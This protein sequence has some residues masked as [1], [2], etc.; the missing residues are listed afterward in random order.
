MTHVIV[1]RWGKNLALRFPNEIAAA[2]QLHEGDRV[3]I[4]SGPEQIVIRR[5]KPRYTLDELFA[6]KSP[7]EWREIYANA[8]DWG[9]DVGQEIID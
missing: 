6:G 3:E 5:A 4:E 9:P 1:G 7:D 8:Y 2:F